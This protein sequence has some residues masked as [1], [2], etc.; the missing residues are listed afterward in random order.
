LNS[1]LTLV[2]FLLGD[3]FGLHTALLRRFDNVFLV[4]DF[5]LQLTLNLIFLY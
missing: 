2:L 1:S 5:T 3:P 4:F